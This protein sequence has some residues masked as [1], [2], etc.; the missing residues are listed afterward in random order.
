M[1]EVRY[2]ESTPRSYLAHPN[3]DGIRRVEF[4]RL[5][6]LKSFRFMII[7]LVDNLPLLR[8]PLRPPLRL[9]RRKS[10]A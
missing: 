2:S 3:Q 9:R 1:R 10:A 6:C 7:Q 5:K 4:Y 8:P